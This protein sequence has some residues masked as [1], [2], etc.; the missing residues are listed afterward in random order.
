M[1]KLSDAPSILLN[2]IS[3]YVRYLSRAV[4]SPMEKLALGRSKLPAIHIGV[5]LQSV[6]RFKQ[7]CGVFGG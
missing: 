1:G 4:F 6:A 3:A 2:S 5:A 7:T